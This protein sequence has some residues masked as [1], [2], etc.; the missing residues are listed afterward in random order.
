MTA[1]SDE[2]PQK[3]VLE[4]LQRIAFKDVDDPREVARF[5]L[6][7]SG[8][9]T[10]AAVYR[11]TFD[12]RWLKWGERVRSAGDGSGAAVV[13]DSEG[14]ELRRVNIG[15]EVWLIGDEVLL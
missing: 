13:V 15:D 11:G 14:H 8:V 9:A 1:V 6:R 3:V 2:S 10:F 5:A 12:L 4:A 7:A